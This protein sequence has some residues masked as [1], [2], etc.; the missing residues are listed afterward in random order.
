MNL[1]TNSIPSLDFH[2]TRI[3]HKAQYFCGLNKLMDKFKLKDYILLNET[4]MAP[5]SDRHW[6]P[7]LP[8]AFSS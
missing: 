3:V 2:G 5:V 4:Y 8:P 7:L 6:A 1:F